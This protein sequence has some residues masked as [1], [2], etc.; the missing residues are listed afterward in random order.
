MSYW[1]SYWII[2]FFEDRIIE[3]EGLLIEFFGYEYLEY[4]KR[5]GILIP[6]IQMD[7]KEEKEHLEEYLKDHPDGVDKLNKSN[8]RKIN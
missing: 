6:F 3:E 7:E 1:F 8:K 5:V 2:Y 4:K